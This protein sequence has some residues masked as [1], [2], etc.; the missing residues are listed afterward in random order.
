[1]FKV[2]L[3]KVIGNAKLTFD[4]LR[5]VLVEVEATLNDRPLTYEYDEVGSEVLTP[6]H[7]IYGRRIT[8]LPDGK[9]V[10]GE[11]V[12]KSNSIARFKYLGTLLEHFW[13]RWK[14]E[15]LTNLREFHKVGMSEKGY[16]SVQPGD[17]VIVFE[18]GKKKRRVE[19]GYCAGVDCRRGWRCSWCESPRDDERSAASVE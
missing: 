10:A 13:S 4:E 1:M 15:Y 17:V 5:T 9:M 6:S 14:R 7:L 18:Q 8:S 2:C 19:N 3:R 12:T 16:V 11:D